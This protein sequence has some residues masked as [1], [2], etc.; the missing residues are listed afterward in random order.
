MFSVI[1][2]TS[3][4]DN[5]HFTSCVFVPIV[6]NDIRHQRHQHQYIRSYKK[7]KRKMEEMYGDD[8]DVTVF[9]LVIV[10]VVD[11][12]KH[13]HR[14]CFNYLQSLFSYKKQHIASFFFKQRW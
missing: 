7:E 11:Y 4:I 12:K 9:L 1:S 5:I 8:D 3:L 10:V 6:R 14:S 13:S 2:G